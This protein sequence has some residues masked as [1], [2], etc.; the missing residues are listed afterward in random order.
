MYEDRGIGASIGHKLSKN[1]AQGINV[2]K[3]PGIL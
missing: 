3:K 2:K 1:N